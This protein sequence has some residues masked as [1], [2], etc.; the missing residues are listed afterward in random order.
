MNSAWSS[1]PHASYP[2]VLNGQ[3]DKH[4]NQEWKRARKQGDHLV[5]KDIE[6]ARRAIKAL[7]KVI[8]SANAGR[9][10]ADYEP[11]QAVDFSSSDR[12]SLNSIEVTEAHSWTG[13]VNTLC[14]TILTTWK[15]IHV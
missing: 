8:T 14:N 13:Q 3:I 11:D 7:A 4:F 15:K 1:L 10:V 2:Q 5:Q 12:F 6:Q 9:V